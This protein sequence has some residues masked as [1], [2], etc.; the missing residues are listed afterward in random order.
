MLNEYI[1]HYNDQLKLECA[2]SKSKFFEEKVTYLG[3]IIDGNE[4][5]ITSEGFR[6][7]KEIPVPENVTAL[8]ACLGMINFY[9]KF[10]NNLSTKSRPLYGLLKNNQ[11]FKWTN[12]YKAANDESKKYA[13]IAY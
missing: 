10:L 6:A 13:A 12:E 2:Q 3:Y 11:Q 1:K 7:I 5:Q 8:R 9:T 4:L